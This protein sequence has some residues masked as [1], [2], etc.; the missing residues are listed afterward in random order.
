[1][2]NEGS[3]HSECSTKKSGF[4]DHVVSRSSLAGFHGIGCCWTV[5]R[6]IIMS[7]D[8]RRKIDFMR[9]LYE[10]LQRRGSRIE[11]VVQGSTR[12]MSSRPRV[13]ASSRVACFP[14]EPRKMQG[15]SITPP[16]SSTA[17]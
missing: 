17:P 9:Q 11:G 2:K 3:A 5:V 14:D 12:A 1:M 6:P 4:E 15:L 10:A 13:S 8:E 16:G 7:E